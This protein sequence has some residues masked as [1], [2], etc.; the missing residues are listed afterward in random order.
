MPFAP[1]ANFE[2]SFVEPPVLKPLLYTRLPS[3]IIVIVSWLTKIDL[4]IR[5]PLEIRNKVGFAGM[6]GKTQSL[7][8]QPRMHEHPKPSVASPLLDQALHHTRPYAIYLVSSGSDSK[9]GLPPGL[10]QL[11]ADCE[12]TRALGQ[13]QKKCGEEGAWRAQWSPHDYT[14]NVSNE[15]S[16]TCAG[17]FTRVSILRI[18]TEAL[19]PGRL[20]MLTSF[21]SKEIE[22]LQQSDRLILENKKLRRELEAEGELKESYFKEAVGARRNV[23]ET[24]Q[25]LESEARVK[26]AG[27]KIMRYTKKMSGMQGNM[28]DLD[29]KCDELSAIQEKLS[30]T[31]QM[32]EKERQEK[33]DLIINCE[34][35]KN[36]IEVDWKTAMR[37]NETIKLQLRDDISRIK[38]S[39]QKNIDEM[40]NRHDETIESLTRMHRDVV[41]VLK[42][43]IES[44]TQSRD[45]Y[46]HGE[47]TRMTKQLQ[48]KYVS[49]AL[50]HQSSLLDY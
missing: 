36:T 25:L 49:Y 37:E 43:D 38:A 30:F 40:N 9:H 18:P 11:R 19:L 8:I 50:F 15:E 21:H 26:F 12:G 7:L 17:R 1:F 45:Y 32:L 2:G 14:T 31:T 27:K 4:M 6:T 10:P 3:E 48:A 35:L 44:I 46:K 41:S 5:D 28:C 33:Q 13:T 42:N 16:K 23:H 34:T 22:R 39:N 20:S 24:V 29:A 47:L